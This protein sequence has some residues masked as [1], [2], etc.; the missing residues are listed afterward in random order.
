MARYSLEELLRATDLSDDSDAEPSDGSASTLPLGGRAAVNYNE[1]LRSYLQDRDSDCLSLSPGDRSPIT[2]FGGVK[3]TDTGA[4]NTPKGCSASTDLTSTC[5]NSISRATS[6]TVT[7]D[8]GSFSPPRRSNTSPLSDRKEEQTACNDAEQP[9]KPEDEGGAERGASAQGSECNCVAKYASAIN[10][11]TKST[12]PYFTAIRSMILQQ[13]QTPSNIHRLAHIYN[14]KSSSSGDILQPSDDENEADSDSFHEPLPTLYPSKTCLDS[15]GISLK[16]MKPPDKPDLLIRLRHNVSIALEKLR[17][18][19]DDFINIDA[20]KVSTTATSPPKSY[21]PSCIAVSNHVLVVGTS[22]G[23]L[24][25]CDITNHRTRRQFSPHNVDVQDDEAG[26][27]DELVWQEIDRQSDASVTCLDVLPESNW[28]CAGYSNAMVKLVQLNKDAVSAKS[29]DALKSDS[30]D[31]AASADSVPPSRGF[32]LMAGAVS[33]LGGFKKSGAHVI[34]SAKPFNDAVAFCKFTLGESHDEIFCANRNSIALLT[35]S[36]TVLSHNLNVTT[37]DAF[38]ERLLEHEE[39]VDVACLSSNPQSKFIT[40]VPMSGLVALATIK[41]C[42]VIATRP[43]LSILFRV[44]FTD[45]P[46]AAQG[47][48]CTIP[49]ITWII[50]NNSGD[51]K[52]VLLIVLSSRISFTLCDLSAG[53]RG[54]PPVSCSHIGYIRFDHAI[55]HVYTVSRDMFAVVDY[56]NVM[57]ILQVNV[58]DNVMH[59]DVVRSFDFAEA[60]LAEIWMDRVNIS[61][62][63]AV[64]VRTV[65]MAAHSYKKFSALVSEMFQGKRNEQH[66]DLRVLSFYISTS[67][68]IWSSEIHSWIKSIGDLTATKYFANAFAISLG[69]CIGMLPG[70]LDYK[71]Y[72]DNIQKLILYVLHQS[73]AQII[74]LSKLMDTAQMASID[75]EDNGGWTDKVKDDIST[76]IDTLC[77]CMLDIC[78]CLGLHDS[79]N[80]LI[81]RCFATVGMQRVFVKYVLLNLHVGRIDLTRL[82]PAVFD[83][84]FEFYEKMLDNLLSVG[85]SQ[86]GQVEDWLVSLCDEVDN[87]Q[88]GQCP[89]QLPRQAAAPDARVIVYGTLCNQLSRLY[90]FCSRNEIPFAKEKAI[91]T[92]SKHSQWHAVVHCPELIGDD[93]AVALE[94][95]YSELSN[96]VDKLR[97]VEGTSSREL[98]A[99]PW[100]QSEGLF[101]TRVFFSFV[102]SFL[103]FANCGMPQDNAAT[104]FCKVLGYLTSSASFKP[105]FPITSDVKHARPELSFEDETVDFDN[106]DLLSFKAAN[107]SALASPALQLLI[108]TCPRLLFACL[109]NLLMAPDSTFEAKTDLLGTKIEIFNFVLESL[110][111]CLSTLEGSQSTCTVRCMMSMF[112]LGVSAFSDSFYI[113]LR[114]QVVA[115]YT[116]LTE[117]GDVNR[118]PFLDPAEL[119][120]D[121]L[122]LPDGSFNNAYYLHS[123]CKRSD[124]LLENVRQFNMSSST[125]RELLKL[126]IRRSLVAIYRKYDCEPS[127][128]HNVHFA[129][130]KRICMGLQELAGDFDTRLFLCDVAA[131]YA[132]AIRACE[133]AGSEIV[134]SYL[135]QCLNCIK[136][137]PNSGELRV[138]EL[139][140]SDPA[141]QKEFVA[142]LM[143]ALPRLIRVDMQSATALLVD[144]LSVSNMASVFKET[145][146]H[147]SQ[148]LII[149]TLGDFPEL[150]MAVLDAL[151]GISSQDSTASNDKEAI[152]S[153][154]PGLENYFVQYLKLLCD[155]DPRG[156]CPFLKR[157]RRLDFGTCLPICMS[158][159]IHDAVAYLFMRA[160]D[161][162]SSSRWLLDAFHASGDD[163]EM[164][165]RLIG[166]AYELCQGFSEFTSHE[167]LEK[168]WFSILRC[169]VDI[170]SKHGAASTLIERVFNV[171]I[172]KFTRLTRALGEL[173]AYESVA[174]SMF[175]H[176]LRMLLCDVDFQT[177]AARASSTMGTTVLCNEFRKSIDCNKR[178]VVVEG[179][180]ELRRDHEICGVCR[181]K[182]WS[183]PQS[184]TGGGE[185]PPPAEG[186]LRGDASPSTTAA[187]NLSPLEKHLGI[188]YTLQAPPNKHAPHDSGS[189]ASN[190]HLPHLYQDQLSTLLSMKPSAGG[191]GR[192][193]WITSTSGLSSAMPPELRAHIRGPASHSTVQVY[194]CGHVFHAACAPRRCATCS[195]MD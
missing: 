167:S 191:L 77:C 25:V 166:D 16:R 14:L 151:L 43:E 64:H 39:I 94:I 163:V 81:Y 138:N 182:L 45:R 106:M 150:K 115:M 58:F 79:L 18:F 179:G 100:D 140:L 146:L 51:I 92:L 23:S 97:N 168:L 28:I 194:W 148:D 188:I 67:Q 2:P 131:D 70:L 52:P 119:T 91:C 113:S 128:T 116:L 74:R 7:R 126:Y 181:R 123:F 121:E 68:G 90:I 41:R 80:D 38:S 178:G 10:K 193:K 83:S 96:R 37:L 186:T 4:W 53:K 162:E 144:T 73:S 173:E 156:V 65:K 3:G 24:L 13:L 47:S 88:R 127:W 176:P 29:A 158:A 17:L 189:R 137:G 15:L 95:L 21:S 48:D 175:K 59:Y 135:R 63:I 69:L 76:Q 98:S 153:V 192:A 172:L 105:S 177:F 164:C 109:M 66:F 136:S 133:S 61:P 145:A 35:Y 27:E 187:S 72:V 174:V 110:I 75:D 85:C 12:C 134:F 50:L 122:I 157:Q 183:T 49:S 34:C 26:S 149:S 55:R 87:R 99:S 46:K 169:T 19:N 44:P 185:D 141:V 170:E 93:I 142:T 11:L 56:N 5:V 154:L 129:N 101:V 111:A 114:T 60:G 118:D 84:I 6:L 180:A 71:A 20:A 143:D 155:H 22:G 30:A 152:L 184:D 62:T 86:S 78:L 112:V 40:G 42:I 165:H 159:N 82:K 132:N 130:M 120:S 32:G 103:T 9:S 36:K 160:G 171:G 195:A 161:F 89:K 54:G 33:A 108:S 102:N 107:G 139:V 117:V 147:S 8:T 57:H 1:V 125:T 190:L 124:D 31:G 104:N